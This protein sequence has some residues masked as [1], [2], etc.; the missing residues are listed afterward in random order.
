MNDIVSLESDIGKIDGITEVINNIAGQTNLLAL[1]AAI[2]AARAGEAGKGFSVVAEEIRKL[3][4]QVAKYS[5]DISQHIGSIMDSAHDAVKNAES[6]SGKMNDQANVIEDT[7]TSF[8]EIRNESDKA[9]MMMQDVTSSLQYIYEDK[10]QI[11]ESIEEISQISTRVSAAA[12]EINASAQQQAAGMN[13][14]LALAQE[15]NGVADKLKKSIDTFSV[16]KN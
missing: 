12:E 8:C 16:G 2:E 9:V 5:K 11:V 1:N 10:Q 13:E 4:D 6:I 3:A 7:V 15:L 14:L